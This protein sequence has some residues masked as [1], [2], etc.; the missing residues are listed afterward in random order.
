MKI[1]I[2][3]SG[4]LL[5]CVVKGYLISHGYPLVEGDE[6]SRGNMLQKVIY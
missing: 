5:F 4:K 1:R 3:P 6:G 2:G